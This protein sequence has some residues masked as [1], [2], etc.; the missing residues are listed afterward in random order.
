[1]PSGRKVSCYD[2]QPPM[3]RRLEEGEAERRKDAR[4]T[5]LLGGFLSGAGLRLLVVALC[6]SLGLVG[7]GEAVAADL[8]PNGAVRRG[9]LLPPKPLE[10]RGRDHS[11]ATAGAE[12]RD[13]L[14]GRARPVNPYTK[15]TLDRKRVYLYTKTMNNTNKTAA[16]NLVAKRVAGGFNADESRKLLVELV[17]EFDTKNLGYALAHNGFSSSRS[18]DADAAALIREAR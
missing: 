3:L 1:M 15:I 13:S 17:S 10:G 14:T 9:V 11:L 8:G 5:L 18:S 12:H 16:E 7:M 6:L 4:V 2:L